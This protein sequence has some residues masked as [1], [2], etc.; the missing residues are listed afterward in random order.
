MGFP[1]FVGGGGGGG[2]YNQDYGISGSIL[3]PP[4]FGQLPYK[5]VLRFNSGLGL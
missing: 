2:V 5:G 4:Y 3:G 1:T